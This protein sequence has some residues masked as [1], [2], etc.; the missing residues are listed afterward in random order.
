MQKAEENNVCF[1]I[2]TDAVIADKFD[3]NAKSKNSCNAH[4]IPD[5][6]MG[7]D[8]GPETGQAFQDIIEKF[9]DHTLERPHGS[10]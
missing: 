8:I 6:W 3:N 2:P 4:E 10:F 1:H 7:L 9:S 5:G